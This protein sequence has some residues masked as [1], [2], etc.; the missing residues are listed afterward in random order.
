MTIRFRSEGAGPDR[1]VYPVVTRVSSD[2][3]ILDDVRGERLELGDGGLGREETLRRMEALAA[4]LR[5][6]NRT[7]AENLTPDEFQAS[8]NYHVRHIMEAREEF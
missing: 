6:L 5:V 1:V 3:D 4:L 8:L 2:D 7:N